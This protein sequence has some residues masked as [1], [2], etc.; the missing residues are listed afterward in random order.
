ML[1]PRL[2]IFVTLLAGASA[3]SAETSNCMSMGPNMVTCNS[4][5]G[6]TT[7]CMSMGPNMASCNTTGGQ[8]TTVMGQGGSSYQYDGGAALGRGL[9]DLIRG[10]NERSFRSKVG[11]MLAAGECEDAY[12]YALKKEHIELGLKLQQYCAQQAGRMGPAEQPVEKR[13]AQMAIRART[14]IEAGP[15]LTLSRVQAKGRELQLVSVSNGTP[16]DLTEARNTL[17]SN[18]C[19]TENVRSAMGDGATVTAY[20]FNADRESLGKLS[21]KANDCTVP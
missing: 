8:T 12:N 6:A 11:K 5:S 2:A 7:N 20:Y 1:S 10:I 17:V 14:P 19:S 3:A 9:G 15:G 18:A 4:S 21:V 16:P 13:L